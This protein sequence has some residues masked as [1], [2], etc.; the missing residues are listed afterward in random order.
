MRDY[1]YIKESIIK[2]LEWKINY[3]NGSSAWSHID[4][5][6][7]LMNYINGV[8]DALIFAGYD[9][10]EFHSDMLLMVERELE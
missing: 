10:K 8:S 1:K 9:I 4:A 3:F 7:T 2:E 5:F 6:C